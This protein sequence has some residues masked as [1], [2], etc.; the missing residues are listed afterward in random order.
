VNDRVLGYASPY[1]KHRRI[2]GAWWSIGL[3]IVGFALLIVLISGKF[4]SISYLPAKVASAL[5]AAAY[6]N[7]IA[8]AVR[9]V[10]RRRSGVALVGLALNGLGSACFFLCLCMLFNWF[11]LGIGFE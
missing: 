5:T 2:I 10:H 3:A 1:L 9:A 7:G 11:G 4:G 8:V 6:I